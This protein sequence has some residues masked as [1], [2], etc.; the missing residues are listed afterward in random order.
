M[1]TYLPKEHLNQRKWHVVDAEGQILGR[2]ATKVAS[3][4]RGKNKPNF[5]SHL[6]CGDFVVAINADKVVLTGKKEEQKIYMTYSGFKGNEKR[7][8]AATV[9][10]KHPER[11]IE[12]A[13]CGMIPRNR[14][15]RQQMTKL[16]VYKGSQHPHTAQQPAEMAV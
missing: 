16:K 12:R 14:L 15:G 6:D 7:Q 9:R 4:L 1:K 2:L 3:V 8:T 10:E 5:T 13:V 11:I